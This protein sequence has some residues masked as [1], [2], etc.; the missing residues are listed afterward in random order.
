MAGVFD[1]TGNGFGLDDQLIKGD[2]TTRIYARIAS[3]VIKVIAIGSATEGDHFAITAQ[4]IGK[5]SI[6]GEKI[7]LRG[8]SPGNRL[9]YSIDS[10]R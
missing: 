5:L 3:V 2:T 1:A 8:A 4:Q 10:P 7:L 9:R 6:G